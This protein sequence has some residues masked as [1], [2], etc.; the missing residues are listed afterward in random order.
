MALCNKYI[1]ININ[2]Y[3]YSNYKNYYA[4][5]KVLYI[6]SMENTFICMNV[7]VLI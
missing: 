1:N 3:V 2:I 7:Q 5:L 6:S 4:V